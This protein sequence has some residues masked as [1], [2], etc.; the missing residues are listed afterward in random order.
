MVCEKLGRGGN[1][2][3]A[4]RRKKKDISISGD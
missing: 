4:M 2:S 1:E 3:D